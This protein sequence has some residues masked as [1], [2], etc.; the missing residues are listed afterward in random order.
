MAYGTQMYNLSM[1]ML[2]LQ[3]NA[4]FILCTFTHKHKNLYRYQKIPFNLFINETGAKMMIVIIVSTS[5]DAKLFLSIL[6]L[7]K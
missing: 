3:C 6:S 5:F 7:R 4:I 2:V 1:S